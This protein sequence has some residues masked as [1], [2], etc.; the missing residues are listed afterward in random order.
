MKDS[1]LI[2][3]YSREDRTLDPKAC[4]RS[5]GA[6][7]SEAVVA[8]ID[9]FSALEG[10]Q[11][12]R[13]S[14]VSRHGAERTG[15]GVNGGHL[16]LA[17]ESDHFYHLSAFESRRLYCNVPAKSSDDWASGA[18]DHPDF[19]L[20]SMTLIGLDCCEGRYGSGV[21]LWPARCCFR[22]FHSPKGSEALVPSWCVEHRT[23]RV[24]FPLH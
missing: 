5:S 13:T 7:K 14:A 20:E 22:I 17:E 1:I 23:T 16:I 18:E 3:V 4:P 15:A 9:P 6:P 10:I 19:W 2:C 8:S 21:M 12:T 11:K 24:F